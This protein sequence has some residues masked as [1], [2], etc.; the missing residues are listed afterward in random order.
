M[1][2]ANLFLSAHD[3]GGAEVLSAWAAIHPENSYR[4]CLQGPA[5]GIFA[6]NLGALENIPLNGVADM[7]DVDP[8]GLILTATSWSSDVEMEIRRLGSARGIRTAAYLDHWVNYRERFGYPGAWLETLP[9]E[10]WCPD[11]ESLEICRRQ[12]FPSSRLLLKGNAYLEDLGRR[13]AES[14]EAEEPDTVLYVCE[15]VG[16]HMLAAHGNARH[17][18]Y[19][20]YEAMSH[21]FAAALAWQPTPRKVVIRPHPSEARGKYES[22][23]TAYRK[24]IEIETSSG[25]SL[26]TDVAKAKT[27]VGCESMAMVVALKAG[28][29]V[30]TSIPPQGEPCSLPFREIK[31]L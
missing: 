14:G 27:V 23:L 18:G 19:D 5:T 21:F 9:D 13:M 7:M 29:E 16:A 25:T 31:A 30:F 11:S 24:L 17:K 3:A 15:P 26:L 28:K 10:I 22:F 20:E 2:S 6:R 1:N 8:P 12:N 4:Y